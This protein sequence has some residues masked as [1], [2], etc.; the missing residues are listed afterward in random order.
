MLSF[1]V[2]ILG[3]SENRGCR[4]NRQSAKIGVGS[5]IGRRSRENFLSDRQS[6]G[7]PEFFCRNCHPGSEP[8]KEVVAARKRSEPIDSSVAMAKSSKSANARSRSF[9]TA[10]MAENASSAA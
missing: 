6:V 3:V 10:K 8:M 7:K 9:A 1:D 5:A 4:Q 2:E